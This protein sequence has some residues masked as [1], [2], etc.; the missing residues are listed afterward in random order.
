MTSIIWQATQKDVVS[1]PASWNASTKHNS[2]WQAP[3][4][5]AVRLNK[6]ASKL[7]GG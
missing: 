5:S 7:W 3:S 6:M 4:E 1:F 2:C